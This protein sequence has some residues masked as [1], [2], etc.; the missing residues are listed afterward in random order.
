MPP[1]LIALM[2][3]VGVGTFTWSRMAHTTG[4]AR[5]GNVIA[6]AAII[7]FIAFLL[8]YSVLKWGFGL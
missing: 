7:G 6:G 4:N 3:G 5:V 1:L 8:L 2:F